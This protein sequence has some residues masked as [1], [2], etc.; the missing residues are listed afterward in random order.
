MTTTVNDG[1]SY[2]TR[3]DSEDNT[4]ITVEDSDAKILR[5]PMSEAK[6]LTPHR[7]T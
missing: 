1:Y 5:A 7:P 6:W 2:L 3:L 4:T